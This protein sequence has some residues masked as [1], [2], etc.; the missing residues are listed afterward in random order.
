MGGGK[1]AAIAAEV[2]PPNNATDATSVRFIV[3]IPLLPSH[4]NV[5]RRCN[6]QDRKTLYPGNNT[7]IE[8]VRRNR[9]LE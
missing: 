6:A 8:T 2:I 3:P 1:S 4:T 9:D 7:T 5:V